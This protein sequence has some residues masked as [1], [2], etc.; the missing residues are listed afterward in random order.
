MA[1]KP[2][3]AP[4][5][6][7][8]VN[9]PPNRLGSAVL[10]G[11][12]RAKAS[13]L[14]QVIGDT[15][16]FRR[17]QQA[18]QAERLAQGKAWL[19]M[20]RQ[21]IDSAKEQGGALEGLEN[22]Y[23]RLISSARELLGA[24]AQLGTRLRAVAVSVSVPSSAPPAPQAAPVSTAQQK[25]GEQGAKVT[26]RPGDSIG[27][28]VVDIGKSLAMF[29]AL[30]GGVA[31]ARRAPGVLTQGL[32]K[33]RGEHGS[34]GAALSARARQIPAVVGEKWTAARQWLG[35]PNSG[36]AV[37]RVKEAPG[38]MLGA[39]AQVR[40]QPGGIGG[41]IMQRVRQV[42][43]AVANGLKGAGQWLGERAGTAGRSV[44]GA[45]KRAT[46][47]GPG[48]PT[49][50]LWSRVADAGRPVANKLSFLDAGLKAAYTYQ[51]ATTEQEKGEG[52]G[53][54]IGGL[55]GSVVGSVIGAAILP[56]IGAPIGGL[57]GNFV[58]D[59]LGGTLGKAWF[60]DDPKSKG[61]PPIALPATPDKSPIKQAPVEPVWKGS[62]DIGASLRESQRSAPAPRL[63]GAP[64]SAM[65]TPPAPINQQFT[66]TAN[67]PVTFIN[68]L[69]DPLFKQ[70][71][72]AIARGQLDELMRQARSVQMYDQS[73]VA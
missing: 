70:R 60:S 30:V 9:W 39:L 14:K 46:G 16:R 40:A 35:G 53:A 4:A 62:G 5:T 29:G 19:S 42:P 65:A 8:A 1:N 59:K 50:S 61:S 28:T 43:A 51:T 15:Q 73:H 13:P 56:V 68:S 2:A 26:E 45:A 7:A 18:A 11:E 21:L 66:F 6:G 55:T 48:A 17:E 67:M 25:A 10:L 41:A 58:G 22:H 71:L 72:E 37:Q 12:P 38:R 69:D 57:I 44:L 32:V 64:P 63:E 20:E 47:W 24:A 54:A 52:Y 27:K 49:G 31:I 23:A 34:V 33:V 36:G 3:L